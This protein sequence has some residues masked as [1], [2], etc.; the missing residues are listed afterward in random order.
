MLNKLMTAFDNYMVGYRERGE[1]IKASNEKALL[2]YRIQKR[3]TSEVNSLVSRANCADRLGRTAC[4]NELKQ[5]ALRL[6]DSYKN[7][8]FY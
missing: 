3:M 5:E 4:S 2:D 1:Q 8:K 6:K 7:R